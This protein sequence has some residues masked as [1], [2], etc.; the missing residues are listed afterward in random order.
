M[1]KISKTNND[2]RKYKSKKT[3]FDKILEKINF[4][5]KNL[6]QKRKKDLHLL[7]FWQ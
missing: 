2:K 3:L 1:G 6:K 5:R 7:N 4:K